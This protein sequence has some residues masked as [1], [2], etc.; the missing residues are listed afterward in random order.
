MTLS[1]AQLRAL[2]G[3]SPLASPSRQNSVTENLQAETEDESLWA[4]MNITRHRCSVSVLSWRHDTQ[5]QD[6]LS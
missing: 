5:C 1:T 2:S 4:T 6:L 3:L